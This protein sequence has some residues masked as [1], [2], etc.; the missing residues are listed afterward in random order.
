MCN[1]K[2]YK[3]IA[4]RMKELDDNDRVV[5]VLYS[6][7]FYVDDSLRG[8]KNDRSY[9][10]KKDIQ[11]NIT[12]SDWYYAYYWKEETQVIDNEEYLVL[13]ASFQDPRIYVE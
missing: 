6:Y 1:V 10:T 5:I 11:D 12:N 13:K 7:G 8:V 9:H 2:R 3:Y 4:D